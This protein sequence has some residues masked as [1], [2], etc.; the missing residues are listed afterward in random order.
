MSNPLPFGVYDVDYYE[1][2]LKSRALKY[3]LTRRTTEVSKAL[4]KYLNRTP[5][6]VLDVGTADALMLGKL[7]RGWP[8]TCFIGLEMNR[9]LLMTTNINDVQ[10]IEGDAMALPIGNETVDAIVATAV[11]EHLPDPKKFVSECNRV[12]K[13][14]GIIVITTPDPNLEHLASKIGLLKESGHHHTFTLDMICQLFEQNKLDIL[15]SRKFMFSPIGFPAEIF[16][17]RLIRY[18]GLGMVLANQLLVARKP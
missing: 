16:I 13:R 15:E 18:F 6:R 17:E 4:T 14:G 2:R 10:K 5:E 12:I 3:R 8:D 7:N 9:S 11:I 1:G